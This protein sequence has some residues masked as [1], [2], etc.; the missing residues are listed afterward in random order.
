M[1]ARVID[2]PSG[3]DANSFIHENGAGAFLE[4]IA[5]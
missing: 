2:M 3:E 1:K 4:R 5:A